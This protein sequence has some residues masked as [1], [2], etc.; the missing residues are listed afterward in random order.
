MDSRSLF[1]PSAVER[2][3]Q[4][5]LLADV[6]KS[7]ADRSVEGHFRHDPAPSTAFSAFSTFSRG[8]NI[9]SSIQQ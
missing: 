6:G 1:T 9:L 7:K 3:P 4:I 5:H 2:A 8:S